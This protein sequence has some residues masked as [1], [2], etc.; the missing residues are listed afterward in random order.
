MPQP[1]IPSNTKT[2][3]PSQTTAKNSVAT[4]KVNMNAR[5]MKVLNKNP[6]QTRQGSRRRAIRNAGNNATR[7]DLNDQIYGP[8]RIK[9]NF[10]SNYSSVKHVPQTY[11]EDTQKSN[12]DVEA[13]YGAVDED[14]DSLSNYVTQAV[15]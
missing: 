15:I 6:A 8:K 14:R 4:S 10:M 12:M 1:N 11:R 7:N 3:T 2:G 9:N 5:I 13:T